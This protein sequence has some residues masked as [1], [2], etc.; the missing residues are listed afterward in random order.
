MS[1]AVTDAM[2]GIE[3]TVDDGTVAEPTRMEYAH[4]PMAKSHV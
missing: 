2:V 1:V 4:G 3:R